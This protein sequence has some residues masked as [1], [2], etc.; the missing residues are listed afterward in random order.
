MAK[1]KPLGHI[2][3]TIIL[4]RVGCLLSKSK[5]LDALVGT[6]THVESV[7]VAHVQGPRVICILGGDKL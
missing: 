2:N 3:F 5:A 4:V 7:V 1:A 6:S